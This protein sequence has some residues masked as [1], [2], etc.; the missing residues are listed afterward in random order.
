[1]SREG[2][3]QKANKQDRRKGNLVTAL[4]IAASQDS[5]SNFRIVAGAL[6]SFEKQNASVW[7]EIARAS[8]NHM[9]LAEA[10]ANSAMLIDFSKVIDLRMSLFPDF[11]EVLRSPAYDALSSANLAIGNL[12]DTTDVIAKLVDQ[13]PSTSEMWQGQ[14]QLVNAALEAIQ[15]S[16]ILLDTYFAQISQLSVLAQATLHQLPWEQIGGALQASIEEQKAI[17]SSFLGIT[18][19]YSD[20]F[21]SF[22]EQPTTIVTLPPFAAELPAVELFNETNLLES[23]TVQDYE[24]AEFEFLVEKEQVQREIRAEVNDKLTVLLA[25]L[26]GD[27]ISLLE[28]ARFSIESDHPD[29]ARHFATS[30][31]ELFTHV[32]HKLA[33]DSEVEK[34]TDDSVHYH[35]KRPTRKARLLYL[36]RNVNHGPFIKFVDADTKAVLEFANLFQGGTHKIVVNYTVEQLNAMLVRMESVLRFMLEIGQVK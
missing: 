26:D 4:E 36:C 34:W 30:L 23:V 7:A 35:N 12:F 25:E 19:S 20:L 1:M 11:S 24:E 16:K 32:L 27:L 3:E 10:V 17:R 28:G 15:P 29:H 2:K 31:R 8:V 33:P 6:K 21:N 13:L 5:I 9:A 22:V 18:Q 14:L